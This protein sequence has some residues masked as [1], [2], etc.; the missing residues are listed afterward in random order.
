MLETPGA[1]HSS[2]PRPRAPPAGLSRASKGPGSCPA[3]S[4]PS[5][6]ELSRDPHPTWLLACLSPACCPFSRNALNIPAPLFAIHPHTWAFSV[7]GTAGA[8]RAHG[9]TVP[10]G[11][12]HQQCGKCW[13]RGLSSGEGENRTPVSLA[14]SGRAPGR[15]PSHLAYVGKGALCAVRL[16]AEAVSLSSLML[17]SAQVS[18]LAKKTPHRHMSYG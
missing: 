5:R 16:N 17:T 11:R 13:L 3:T 6:P 15:A 14:G 9:P 10:G 18:A 1:W 7:P 12:Q 2:A 8:L 4:E